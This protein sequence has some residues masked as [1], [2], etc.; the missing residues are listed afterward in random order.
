MSSRTR[1]ME[2]MIGKMFKHL[3]CPILLRQVD[4]ACATIG[5]DRILYSRQHAERMLEN[6]AG[7]ID[8]EVQVQ[9]SYIDAHLVDVWSRCLSPCKI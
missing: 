5:P 1:K 2:E 6:V 7:V 4:P 3:E 9:P 8:G